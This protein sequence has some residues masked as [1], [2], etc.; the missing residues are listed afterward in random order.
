MVLRGSRVRVLVSLHIF[1]TPTFGAERGTVT[2]YGSELN[3]HCSVT[4]RNLRLNFNIA[5]E[6]VTVHD[7]LLF[8]GECVSSVGRA[9]EQSIPREF[10]QAAHF[11]YPV[12][13]V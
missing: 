5:G 1:L 6:Y 11:S 4:L 13:Y 8:R 2:E 12:T 9:A 10:G 3:S 7:Y